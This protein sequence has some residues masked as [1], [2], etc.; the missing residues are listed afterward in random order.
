[1]KL[2]P[3]FSNFLYHNTIKCYCQVKVSF[4]DYFCRYKCKNNGFR[5][6]T[7]IHAPILDGSGNAVVQYS[8]DAWGKLLSTIGSMATTLGVHNPL[9]YRGYVYDHETSLYYLQS[10]Y[11]DPELGRFL[12]ADAFVATETGLLGN[13]MFAYCNNNPVNLSDPKSTIPFYDSPI[14]KAID[15]FSLWYRESDENETDDMGK[16]TLNARIKRF[17]MITGKNLEF[18]AGIGLGLYK[19]FEVLDFGFDAGMYGNIGSIHYSGGEWCTGQELYV[20]CTSSMIQEYGFSDYTFMQGGRIVEHDA[21]GAFNSN[22]TSIT[23]FSVSKYLIVGGS[24]SLGFNVVS[25]AKDW[26]YVME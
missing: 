21:W 25:F 15:D 12:N 7:A 9:R 22:Q 1:M 8:Y 6:K 19:D 23:L 18:S 4:P 10:R 24:I 13:N 20:G 16:L 26:N 5:Q 17:A 3:F 11:Y 2:T 14:Q